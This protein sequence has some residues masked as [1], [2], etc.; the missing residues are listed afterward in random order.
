MMVNSYRPPLF[1]PS[2]CNRGLLAPAKA[3]YE[4][5]KQFAKHVVI[6]LKQLEACMLICRNDLG[7]LGRSGH[8]KAD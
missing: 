7:A 8:C 2:E 3:L 1:Q 6:L 5:A 4:S